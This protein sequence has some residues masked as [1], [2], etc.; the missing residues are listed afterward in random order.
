MTNAVNKAGIDILIEANLESGDSIEF[1]SSNTFAFSPINNQ[2][3]CSF[4]SKQSHIIYKA[5]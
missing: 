2:Y 1:T 3:L 4:K 5:V